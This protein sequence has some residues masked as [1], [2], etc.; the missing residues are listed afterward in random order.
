VNALANEEVGAYLNGRFVA[1]FQ[2][3]GTF[4]VAG[5]LKLGGNVASYFC[6]PD[7]SVLHLIP[8][9]VSSEV[10]LRE[11][12]WAY[13]SWKMATLEAKVDRKRFAEVITK[14]HL[15]RLQSEYGLTANQ[16]LR[17]GSQVTFDPVYVSRPVVHQPIM[18]LTQQAQAH[19]LLARNPMVKIEKIYKLVFERIL[20]ERV[21]T[22]PVTK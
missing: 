13:E 15:G 5:N 4:T 6:L 18:I 17:K 10:F 1:T 7:G 20:G 9:P 21:S 8:G 14:G 12:R 19:Q 3:V 16:V 22:Q 2:K 11:A